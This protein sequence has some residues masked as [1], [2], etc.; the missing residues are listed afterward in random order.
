[1]GYTWWKSHFF[2]KS[3]FAQFLFTLWHV[4]RRKM[5][6]FS[7][8]KP[9]K[10]FQADFWFLVRFYEI[11]DKNRGLN[12]WHHWRDK[13]HQWREKWYQWLNKWYQFGISL[14]WPLWL[15]QMCDISGHI[16]DISGRISDINGHMNDII[17]KEIQI[18]CDI[19]HMATFDN[20]FLYFSYCILFVCMYWKFLLFKLSI[21]FL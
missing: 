21:L 18:E 19:T 2:L 10:N 13:W 8:I 6:I 5:T 14:T 12:K 4:T 1:M 3:R 9:T 20:R 15:G 7:I 16:S 11:W 17:E